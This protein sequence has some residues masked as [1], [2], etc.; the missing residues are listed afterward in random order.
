MEQKRYTENDKAEALKLYREGSGHK[1]VARV[2]GIP[3]ETVRRWVRAAG[4]K[5]HPHE[6]GGWA[7]DDCGAPKLTRKCPSCSTTKRKSEF[8]KD[9]SRPDGCQR[10]CK[11]CSNTSTALRAR[12]RKY[13]F[14]GDAWDKAWEAS[15]GKC[16][17]CDMP[18]GE[19]PSYNLAVDHDHET[20]A[21]RGLL[22]TCCNLMIGY[23]GD[24]P[25]ILQRAQEYL[26]NPP[27]RGLGVV[28]PKDG[29][30]PPLPS[31][32]KRRLGKSSDPA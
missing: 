17:I 5:P 4:V 8:A 26:S 18:L 20:G 10:R 11:D 31:K 27:L 25:D 13:G 3:R 1:A 7:K 6:N 23:A 21:V 19:P 9:R 28:C 29:G 24:R 32:R 14:D 30:P 15:G 22:C 16:A 12:W 2:L